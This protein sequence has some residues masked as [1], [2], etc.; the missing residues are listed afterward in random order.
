MTYGKIAQSIESLKLDKQVNLIS[1]QVFKDILKKFPK[2]KPHLSFQKKLRKDQVKGGKVGCA[3]DGGIYFWKNKQIVFFEAKKQ[4]DKGNAIERAYKNI[5]VAQQNNPE[6]NY[7]IFACG[8]GAYEDGMIGEILSPIID[9]FNKY[10]PRQCSCF[11]NVSGF[12]DKFIYDTMYNVIKESIK[13]E[14]NN[15]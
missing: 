1:Q 13:Y 7:I 12:T 9:T 11:M 4:N 14:I 10:I 15:A 8:S 3:P 6:I 5:F 2:Y